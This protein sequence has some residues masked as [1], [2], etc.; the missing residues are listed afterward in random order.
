M[1]NLSMI[2]DIRYA[3]TNWRVVHLLGIT[4]L[5]SRY[6]RSKFGQAWL[7]ITTL[8]QILCTGMVWSLIW[9]MKISEYLP[10]VGVG[11]I[12]YL[13]LS[14]TINDST[15][16]FVSDAR[17]YMNDKLPFMIS[18][19][20]HIYRNL[21]ILLHNVPTVIILLLWSSAVH[22]AITLSFLA[23]V[24]LAFI[25]VFF[26]CYLLATIC[27]RFRDLIQLVSLLFQIIFLVSP[28]MWKVS[29]LPEQ[30]QKYA[31]INPFAS[32]LELLRN[33]LLGLPV[34][35]WALISLSAWTLLISVVSIITFKKM[36]R[37]TIYWI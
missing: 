17:L 25:F 35:S 14:Q 34:N 27:T 30:Y 4:A 23:G 11:H 18:I 32:L 2:S 1:A 19:G 33:P 37:Y 13:F 16:A 26:S 3:A 24:V 21:L 28:I 29:F 8:I 15:G 7:S 36:S 5:R 6:A 12:V 22:P 31:Y 10:Y 9:R 20:A